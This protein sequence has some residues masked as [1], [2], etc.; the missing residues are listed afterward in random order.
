MCPSQV[1]FL[2]ITLLLPTVISSLVSNK[3]FSY[4]EK[5]NL[6]TQYILMPCLRQ[7]I[8]MVLEEMVN[9]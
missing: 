6:G 1:L 5:S 3:H 2:W 7:G 4:P 8:D 9:L